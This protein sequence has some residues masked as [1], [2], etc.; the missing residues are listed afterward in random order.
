GNAYNIFILVLTVASLLIVVLLLL[1]IPQAVRD[2]LNVYDNVVCVLFL[3]DFAYNLSGSRP[4]RGYFIS[5]R[6]WLDLLGSIPSLGFFQA[7][8]A[9]LP[10][11]RPRA[12]R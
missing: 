8:G 1:P 6:G 9:L 2:L 3:G 11:R 12:P 7:T 4:K 10:A 5:Q